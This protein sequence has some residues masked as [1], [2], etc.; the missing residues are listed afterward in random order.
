VPPRKSQ[1]DF[2]LSWFKA[3]PGEEIPH[4]KSKTEIEVAYFDEYGKRLEDSD[5]AIR[6]LCDEG[7]LIKVGK[8]IYKY[9][10]DLVEVITEDFEFTAAQKKAILKRDGNKCVVCGLGTIDGM[11]L[12]IDHIIPRKRG[13]KP[14]LENGQTLCGKHNYQKKVSGQTEFGKKMFI[15]LM[16][17]LPKDG[18]TDSKAIEAFC[19]AILYTYEEHGFDNHIYWHE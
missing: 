16:N 8:G 6:S 19:L 7:Y 13:G 4:T 5:R 3:R 10:P 11:E 2:V 12:Q 18:S 1:K 17:S 14:T 15:R 9:D